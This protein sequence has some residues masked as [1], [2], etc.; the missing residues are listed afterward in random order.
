MIKHKFPCW[1]CALVFGQLLVCSSLPAA[2]VQ[3]GD[4][5]PDAN[6]WFSFTTGY[7][8][9]TSD[10][11]VLVDGGS[12]LTSR[13]AILGR[14]AGATGTATVI[15]TDSRWT[16]IGSSSFGDGN[17]FVGNNGNGILSIEVGGEVNNNNSYLGRNANSTGSAIVTGPGSRWTNNYWLYVGN[18][19]TGTL[20]VSDGGEVTNAIGLLGNYAGSVGTATVTGTGS[21]WHNGELHVGRDGSGTLT[22][23]DGGEVVAGRLYASLS[24]LLGDGTI[25][26]T[27]GG[28]LDA[29]LVFDAIQ[30]NQTT[31]PFGAGGTLTIQTNGGVLGVGYRQSGSLTVSDG[32]NVSSSTGYLGYESG[33]TGSATV[34]GTG[35]KWSNSGNLYVGEWGNGTLTIEA[36][37]QV[38]N[39]TGLIGSRS[40]ST[41]TVTVMGSGSQWTNS[42]N[43]IIGG[44]RGGNTIGTLTIGAGGQVS[45]LAGRLGANGSGTATVTG[46]GSKWTSGYLEVGQWGNGTLIIEE[47]G[48]VSTQAGVVSR[49]SG[50]MGTAIVTGVG[51]KWINSGNL[52][53]GQYG[54]GT[55]TITNGGKVTVGEA[56]YIAPNQNSAGVINMA[57]GGMLALWGEADQSLSAFLDIISGTGQ[58]RFWDTYLEDW[59]PLTTATYGEDYT[60]EYL[61][62]GE[63]AG[64]T[65]LTVGTLG[66]FDG[67][68]II[69][70]KDFLAWQRNPS[71]GNLADWETAFGNSAPQVATSTVVPE[72]SALWLVAAGGLLLFPSR[73]WKE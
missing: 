62:T 28:V 43:L 11:S 37:G 9:R 32:D 16:N 49:D 38:S 3:T 60:L 58:I 19:G 10:G 15:G 68:G 6:S 2:I 53:V 17:L 56:L 29:E 54:S 23:S 50:S 44:S 31:V 4:V 39:A 22:V 71:L 64:Y 73:L 47:G 7:I 20:T 52:Y 45:S 13:E 36:G 27:N 21:K 1:S 72:P 42:G 65:L 41:G 55:L 8:G 48:Q 14:D 26:A 5:V 12:E 25:T 35:S 63:L 18:F 40:G 59:A 61:T 30:V 70:G 34:T 24:N 66:D 51:S 67:D 57:T 69:D 33:S 46:S